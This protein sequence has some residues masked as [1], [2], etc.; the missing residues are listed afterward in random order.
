MQ[1]TASGTLDADD[2]FLTYTWDFGDGTELGQGVFAAHAYKNPGDYTAT[3]TVSDS[4]GLMTKAMAKVSVR[5]GVEKTIRLTTTDTGY[6]KSPGTVSLKNMPIT[7][8]IRP[9]S[10]PGG[11]SRGRSPFG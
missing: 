11:T 9:S 1:F 7:A 10:S 8:A 4:D 3:L 6:V 5:A 2:N